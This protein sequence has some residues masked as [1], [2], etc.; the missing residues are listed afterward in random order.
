MQVQDTRNA[1]GAD[2]APA[3]ESAGGLSIR[4]RG[5]RVV[6]ALA[7]TAVLLGI[8]WAAYGATIPA[9]TAPAFFLDIVVGAAVF[10]CLGFAM[11]SVIGGVD[12]AQRVVQAVILPLSFSSGLWAVAQII[13]VP[14]Q[15][16]PRAG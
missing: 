11:A 8:G 5:L 9:R 2:P 15:L 12:A 4:V 10:C 16:A 3:D 6:T 7:I 1:P 14:L 13:A